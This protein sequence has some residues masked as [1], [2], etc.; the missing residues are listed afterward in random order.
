MTVIHPVWA[1]VIACAWF[2]VLALL[3]ARDRPAPLV[4]T[5]DWLV[6]AL[7]WLG[8]A[9]TPG[10][11]ARRARRELERSEQQR[12]LDAVKVDRWLAEVLQPADR[13]WLR[14]QAEVLP[15]R[16]AILGAREDD[17]RAVLIYRDGR[18]Q[19]SAPPLPPC[20]SAS[21]T[22]HH[23]PNWPQ[24]MPHLGPG[25]SGSS[26]GQAAPT[27]SPGLTRPWTVEHVYSLQVRD[28][29]LRA[30]VEQAVRRVVDP[31]GEVW[32][33]PDG[34]QRFVS[35]RGGRTALYAEL[36]RSAD[37]VTERAR[38]QL[39]NSHGGLVAP[40]PLPE[41]VRARWVR[42][43]RPR[44]GEQGGRA[45]RDWQAEHGLPAD[46]YWGPACEAAHLAECAGMVKR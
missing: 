27:S 33:T 4:A 13:L 8:T 18:L 29:Q 6:S 30:Q 31:S 2:G 20:G 17:D 28:L 21:C 41:S 7:V 25:G 19:Y 1:A 11:R 43:G 23:E 3:I 35:G 22:E 5:W 12:G 16:W 36:K 24:G 38:R 15:E 42:R 44:R 39:P 45:V 37:Q 9:V 26:S 40:A 14:R 46:G 34:V 10:A 32:E